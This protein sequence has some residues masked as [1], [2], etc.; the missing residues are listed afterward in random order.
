MQALHLLGNPQGEEAALPSGHSSQAEITQFDAGSPSGSKSCTEE[1]IL[2][3]S[4]KHKLTA[5][6]LWEGLGLLHQHL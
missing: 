1:T 4:L 2:S 3:R 5:R 6:A